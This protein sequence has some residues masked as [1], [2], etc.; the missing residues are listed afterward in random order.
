MNN[1]HINSLEELI[2]QAKK[3]TMS[4]AENAEQ[5]R[6]FA[7]GNSAFENDRIT[8][9]MILDEDKKLGF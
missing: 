5:R 4:P 9:E 8:K 2:E 1:N 6:S 7:F 3:I